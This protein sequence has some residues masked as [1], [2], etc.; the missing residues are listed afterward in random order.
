MNG[1]AHPLHSQTILR[2]KIDK[3]PKQSPRASQTYQRTRAELNALPDIR[4]YQKLP[5]SQFLI[6]WSDLRTGEPYLGVNTERPHTGY[7]LYFQRPKAN[8][9]PS[10]PETYPPIYTVADGVVTRVDSAFRLLPIYFP[11]R[12]KEVSNIRFGIDLTFARKGK[13][14]V[15]F[16][17][18]IEPM[19][20]PGN[21]PF[22]KPFL[23]VTAG[24]GVQQ[25]DTIAFMYLPSD[26]HE[27][28]AS[29]IHFNLIS[30]CQFQ[31]PSVF[32]ESAAKC[33]QTT[34][35]ESR[36]K[37]IAKRPPFFGFGLNEQEN[38]F[39]TGQKDQL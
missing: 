21:D 8:L 28:S 20:D 12:G 36:D 4:E 29:H 1:I 13:N 14:P 15:S 30:G 31:S 27:V 9:D 25:G 16:H 23:R 7:H 10:K 33:F 38:P 2:Q 35:G 19:T 6:D 3:E 22:S 11:E 34:W 26:V 17:Y 24:Y 5:S 39:G 18:R 32:D 37:T